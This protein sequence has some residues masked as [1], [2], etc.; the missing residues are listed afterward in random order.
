MRNVEINLV[1]R[2][3]NRIN[4]RVDFNHNLS[5]STGRY[6]VGIS[7]LFTG[8]NPSLEFDLITLL[9]STLERTD[10]DSIGGWLDTE[11]NIYYVDICRNFDSLEE[12]TRVG[13]ELNEI[14]IY[15]LTD[16]VVINM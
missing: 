9:G 3:N 15:D 6:V 1:N 12:S 8:T 7:N 4:S 5:G 11:T 2:I 10:I 13:R 14:S 16:E